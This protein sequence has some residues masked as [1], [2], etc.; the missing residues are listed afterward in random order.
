MVGNQYLAIWLERDR[1]SDLACQPQVLASF[2]PVFN[3]VTGLW[4]IPRPHLPIV[5]ASLSGQFDEVDVFLEFSTLHRCGSSCWQAT[6]DDCECSCLGINHARAAANVE[7]GAW[8]R[9]RPVGRPTYCA[10][11]RKQRHLRIRRAD[12]SAM[13]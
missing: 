6:D 4:Q 11:T 10:P 8:K 5:V 3:E 12:T 2:G 1:E 13:T 9:W 7:A